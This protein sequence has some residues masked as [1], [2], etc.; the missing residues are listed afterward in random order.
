[1]PGI[2]V[3]PGGAGTLASYLDDLRDLLH[4][5]SDR[6]WPVAR[7]T[8][9]VNKGL[10]KRDR[11]TGQNRVLIPFTTTVGVDVYSF[12]DLGNTNVFDI[13]GINLLFQ[14]LR[15][16]I[17]SYSFSELNVRLR[18]YNPPLQWAPVGFARYGPNQFVIAPAPAIPY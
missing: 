18:Q 17:G 16:V 13:I 15:I 8:R 3:S 7:K 14:N 9:Y 12:T 10:Q 11:D 6:I 5:E 4:D 2:P 1:M